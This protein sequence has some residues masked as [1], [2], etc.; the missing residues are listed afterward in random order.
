MNDKLEEYIWKHLWPIL[1]YYT[2]LVALLKTP[3]TS[4][5][6]ASASAGIQYIC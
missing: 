3:E 2:F 6:F 4:V 1:R 5:T